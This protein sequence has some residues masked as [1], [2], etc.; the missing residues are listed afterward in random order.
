MP[1]AVVLRAGPGSRLAA[2]DLSAVVGTLALLCMAEASGRSVYFDVAL[3]SAVLAFA[4]GMVFA[5]FL[6]RWL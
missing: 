6:E 2:L 4:S 5:R 1:A 3:V